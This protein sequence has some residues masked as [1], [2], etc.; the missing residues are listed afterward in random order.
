M[1]HH[2]YLR[3]DERWVM[4]KGIMMED[5]TLW[6]CLVCKI[7]PSAQS[8]RKCPQCRRN[9]IRWDRSKDP[10]ERQPEWPTLGNNTVETQRKENYIDYTQF[11]KKIILR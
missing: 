2:L 9:L 5:N 10:T 11:F 6:V 4:L 3:V 7:V 8:R 1:V